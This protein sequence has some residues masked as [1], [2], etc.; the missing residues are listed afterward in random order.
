MFRDDPRDPDGWISQ[1][2]HAASEL[3]RRLAGPEELKQA[4]AALAENP[5]QE[6]WENLQAIL[7]RM[8]RERLDSGTGHT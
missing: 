5:S 1:W 8:R 4:E 2:R 6:N 7:T 3:G